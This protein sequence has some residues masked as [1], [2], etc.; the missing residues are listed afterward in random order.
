MPA[1]LAYPPS[2]L[3]LALVAAAAL[4]AAFGPLAIIVVGLFMMSSAIIGTSLSARLSGTSE[5]PLV[6]AITLGAAHV[7]DHVHVARSLAG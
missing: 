5:L 3:G 2:K 4:A 1:A 7:L 6:F